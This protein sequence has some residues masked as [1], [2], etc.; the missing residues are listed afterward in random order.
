PRPP[1]ANSYC[2][3][4]LV[5]CTL[6]ARHPRTSSRAGRWPRADRVG[7]R[8]T[9][10][11]RPRPSRGR[12]ATASRTRTPAPTSYGA[13]Y[14]FGTGVRVGVADADAGALR[15]SDGGTAPGRLL[16][17]RPGGRPRRAGA[18]GGCGGRRAG[19]AGGCGGRVRRPPGCTESPQPAG[20][21]SVGQLVHA[22]PPR[23]VH[24][25]RSALRYEFAHSAAGAGGGWHALAIAGRPSSSPPTRTSQPSSYRARYEFGTGVRVRGQN[26]AAG[27]TP[28]PRRPRPATGDPGPAASSAAVPQPVDEQPGHAVDVALV[29]H[30]RRHADLGGGVEELV[31][32]D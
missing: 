12:Q 5:R 26:G 32:A 22:S 7:T 28:R 14:E 9:V 19:A 20:P 29:E 30:G 6:R 17:R 1:P 11:R 16:T 2:C 21:P 27:C 3:A 4:E 31:R 23:T 13:R 15:A 25:T 24:A 10:A 8:R 18:A